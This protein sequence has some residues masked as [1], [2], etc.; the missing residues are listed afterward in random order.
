MAKAGRPPLG[1][2]PMTNA[3]K[4][5]R[6]RLNCAGLTQE[7]DDLR[8][9]PVADL[10]R[11]LWFVEQVVRNMPPNLPAAGASNNP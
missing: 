7:L 2:R 4:I 5:R 3:E 10:E 8:S 9:G 6:H 11:R 1:E